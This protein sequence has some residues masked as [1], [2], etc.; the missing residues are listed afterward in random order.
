MNLRCPAGAFQIYTPLRQM[1][2]KYTAVLLDGTDR[3]AQ[4]QAA[5]MLAVETVDRLFDETVV[6]ADDAAN[7]PAP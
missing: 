6:I 7:A 1:Y 5:L 2:H 4:A 3:Q